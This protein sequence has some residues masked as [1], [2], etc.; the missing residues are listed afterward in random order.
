LS[1][2]EKFLPSAS[3]SSASSISVSALP[4]HCAMNCDVPASAPLA[5]A[6]R[7]GWHISTISP[8]LPPL[9]SAIATER[10]QM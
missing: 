4:T 10:F 6:S 7:I 3:S 1:D 5:A 9:S 2:A 8:I